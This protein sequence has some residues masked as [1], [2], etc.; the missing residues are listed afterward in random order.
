MVEII[1]FSILAAVMIIF[2]SWI[3]FQL[4][5][6]QR[7]GEIIKYLNSLVASKIQEYKDSSDVYFGHKY[8]EYFKAIE[9]IRSFFISGEIK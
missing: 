6:I 5:K 4:G 9:D 3:F 7:D 2:F 1:E 8:K